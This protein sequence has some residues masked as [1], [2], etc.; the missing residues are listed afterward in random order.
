[1]PHAH[2]NPRLF[3]GHVYGMQGMANTSTTFMVLYIV[4]KYACTPERYAIM[5]YFPCIWHSK[6]M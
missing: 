5:S 4:E 6:P 1:M 2:P 3:T